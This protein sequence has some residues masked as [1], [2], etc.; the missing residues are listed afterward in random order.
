M[1]SRARRSWAGAGFT[2]RLAALAEGDLGEEIFTNLYTKPGIQSVFRFLDEESSLNEDLKVMFS[3]N[4]PQFWKA[5]F[6][7][8]F[9]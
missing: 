5:F 4:K 9:R 2:G 7:S 3:L 1:F 8:F 6:S